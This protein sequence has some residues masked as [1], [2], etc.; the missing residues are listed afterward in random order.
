MKTDTWLPHVLC[1]IVGI[2]AWIEVNALFSELGIMKNLPEGR[3]LPSIVVMLVQI[4]NIFPLLFSLIPRKPEL[5]WSMMLVL[6]L[7]IASLVFLS[8]LWE[9]T[10]HIFGEERSLMLYIGGFMAAGA[11]CLSNIVFW[12]YVGQFPRSYITAMGTG[13]SLSS[14]VSAVVAASQKAAG[15]SPSWFFLIILMIVILS[16]TAFLYLETKYAKNL[17]DQARMTAVELSSP[18]P[19]EEGDTDMSRLEVPSW[20][21]D[22]W[23][24]AIIAGIAFVQN[25]LNPSLLP[26]ACK[27]YSNAYWI[28]QN[29]LFVASPVMSISAS[30]IKPRKSIFPAV[31]CWVI[32]SVFIITAAGSAAPLFAD[33][34]VGKIVTVTV[35]IISGASLA[36]SKVSA[37]LLLRSKRA[38]KGDRKFMQSLM[39]KAGIAMQVGSVCGAVSMFL[40]IQVGKV[41]S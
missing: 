21:S 9:K 27:G 26:Y 13:E 31:F 5:R 10:Y 15:F 8:I 22:I 30:F 12:P 3:A 39:T 18:L 6:S 25:G 24:F 38:P 36:Y 17:A 2:S 35:S 11:D 4:G 23:V 7:G 37:M 28:S 33:Q 19:I 16:S 29:A 1:A 32:S 34:T 40:L 41:F 14:A 20:R